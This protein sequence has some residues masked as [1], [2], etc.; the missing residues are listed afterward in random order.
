MTKNPY[1]GWRPAENH[2][3]YFVRRGSG[4]KKPDDDYQKAREYVWRTRVYWN[5]GMQAKVF[6]V[7]TRGR[8][9][10]PPAST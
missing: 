2:G 4:G 10:S 6:A 5:G 3:K 8:Q 9:V 1:L 7:T